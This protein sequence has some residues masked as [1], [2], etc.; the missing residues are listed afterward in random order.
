MVLPASSSF[1]PQR[2]RGIFVTAA[3]DKQ[4]GEL[5]ER[6]AAAVMGNSLGVWEQVYDKNRVAR[7]AAQ[8]VAALAKWRQQVLAAAA[9][10]G[11]AGGVGA[12]E[13]TGAAATP[14]AAEAAAAVLGVH[15]EYV[16]LTMDLD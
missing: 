10:G 1:G 4:L 8:N 2:A 12:A 11:A 5:D 3:R 15:R 6:A 13:A 14:S 9:R 7:A 16:D